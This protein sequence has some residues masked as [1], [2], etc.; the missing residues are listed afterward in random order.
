[1]VAKCIILYAIPL[2]SVY[3]IMNLPCYQKI[4][5]QRTT[6]DLYH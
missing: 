4:Y 3:N 5:M 1:M 2:N 6:L